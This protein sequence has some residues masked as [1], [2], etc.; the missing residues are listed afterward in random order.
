MTP[1]LGQPTGMGTKGYPPPS[2][3]EGEVVNEEFTDWITLEELEL[4]IKWQEGFNN[5]QCR[6]ARS[7]GRMF[8]RGEGAVAK[9][10][11]KGELLGLLPSQ[12][13]N[14]KGLAVNLVRVP[15]MIKNEAGYKIG[16]VQIEQNRQITCMS[17]NLKVGDEVYWGPVQF[18]IY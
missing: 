4:G 11:K 5:P 3:K 8:F 18:S 13:K 16:V 17:D 10:I 9:E 7:I 2:S 6:V 14:L 15:I 12:F 1:I